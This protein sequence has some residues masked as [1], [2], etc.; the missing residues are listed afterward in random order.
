ML[1]TSEVSVRPTGQTPGPR[2]ITTGTV[3]R[4]VKSW[5]LTPHEL[6][7]VINS[8]EYTLLLN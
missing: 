5:A 1:A 3:R 2:L 4:Y 6:P 7:K 8:N